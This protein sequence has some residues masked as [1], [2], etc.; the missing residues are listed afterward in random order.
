MRRRGLVLLA[1][2]AVT[3]FFGW[4]AA[5][6]RVHTAFADL[7][8]Q[9]HPYVK[10]HNEFH[11]TFGGGNLVLVAVERKD[12]TV[13]NHETLRKIEA[14][15]E[16]VDRMDGVNHH[17]LFSIAHRK[18]K[19]VEISGSFVEQKAVMWPE[20]PTD[21]DEIAKIRERVGSSALLCGPY[22]SPDHSSVLITAQ[23]HDGKMDYRRLFKDFKGLIERHTDESSV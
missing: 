8:P 16:A 2:L 4:K 15:T 19:T 18:A 5:E 12:G 10:I 20:I 11:K 17:Q 13:F 3:V 9:E 7:L 21:P 6:L 22:V 14:I 23:F 1:L